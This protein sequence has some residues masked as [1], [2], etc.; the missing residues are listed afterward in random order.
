MVSALVWQQQIGLSSL[1]AD[2]RLSI[3]RSVSE[4]EVSDLRHDS[5]PSPFQIEGKGSLKVKLTTEGL[6]LIARIRE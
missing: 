3:I 2:Q 6:M 1:C 5:L 4:V